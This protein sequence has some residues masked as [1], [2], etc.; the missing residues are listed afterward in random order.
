[1]VDFL[2]VCFANLLLIFCSV[3]LT[4]VAKKIHVMGFCIL[5]TLQST[6]FCVQFAPAFAE[7]GKGWGK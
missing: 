5:G 6:D 2:G 4:F 1:M 3:L 7:M